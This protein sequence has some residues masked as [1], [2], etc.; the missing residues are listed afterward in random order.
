MPV[1]RITKPAILYPTIEVF[2]AACAAQRINGAYVKY[3]VEEQ[4][5]NRTIM[6]ALLS[7]ED[8]KYAIT[9]AD[10]ESAAQV[11]KYF[12]QLAFKSIKA[13]LN[14]YELSALECADSETVTT[15]LAVATIASLPSAHIR[16]SA[17]DNIEQRLAWARGGFIGKT[18]D[19]IE[20][21][22]EVLRVIFSVTYGCYFVTALTTAD[23]PVFFSSSVGYAVGG[24][25][26][27]RGTVKAH[28]DTSTQLSRVKVIGDS[29]A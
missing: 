25:L 16:G 15:S 8:G 27:I 7:G 22:I 14:S 6:A 24:T 29:N 18:G 17:K 12:K 1:P 28:R 10:R 19:K 21:E 11:I 13:P 4:E 23:E 3:P 5:T 20:R 26:K 9:D 2:A